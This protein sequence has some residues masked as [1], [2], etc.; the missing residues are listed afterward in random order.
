MSSHEATARGLKVAALAALVP[1][2][3]G[4]WHARRLACR[5]ERFTADERAR[6]A[7]AAGV[8]EASR[9]TWALLVTTVR[10]GV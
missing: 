5:L 6:W 1:P 3:R 7:R 2:A 4:R 8:R 9:L 10:E